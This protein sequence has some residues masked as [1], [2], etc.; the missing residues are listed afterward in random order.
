MVGSGSSSDEDAAESANESDME[1]LEYLMLEHAARMP[2]GQA[3]ELLH[4]M[5]RFDR[6][7]TRTSLRLQELELHRQPSAAASQQQQQQQLQQQRFEQLGVSD[8]S[9]QDIPMPSFSS[10]KAT[11]E[12]KGNWRKSHSDCQEVDVAHLQHG[13]SETDASGKAE[14]KA[15]VVEVSAAESPVQECSYCFKMWPWLSR[16]LSIVALLVLGALAFAVAYGPRHGTDSSSGTSSS[17]AGECPSVPGAAGAD[18]C[19][20]QSA[21]S[22]PGV[23]Q[24][25]AFTLANDLARE[26]AVREQMNRA[27]E[28]AAERMAAHQAMSPLPVTAPIVNDDDPQHRRAA[29][30]ERVQDLEGRGYQVLV[31]PP[32]EVGAG[33]GVLPDTLQ[34]Q[35]L[36]ALLAKAGLD[37]KIREETARRL[38]LQGVT[39]A[40]LLGAAPEDLALV[41][42]APDIGLDAGARFRLL[43]GL[44]QVLAI[45]HLPEGQATLAVGG[46]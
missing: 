20:A 38:L 11:C 30:R 34:I 42:S 16:L 26:Q 7:Q 44:K 23:Q 10:E 29:L 22:S 37:Q 36:T 32:D 28:V 17:S 19:S 45:A 2:E 41:L 39:S 35:E 40:L 6:R 15:P 18:Q 4:K 9:P 33:G 25:R 31:R 43:Q 8:M 14:A 3:A 24:G 13:E 5:R 27:V 12:V 1:P 46:G 21:R